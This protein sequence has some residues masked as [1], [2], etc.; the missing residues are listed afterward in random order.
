[1]ETTDT[2]VR[3]RPFLETNAAG[4][5][6]SNMTTV[7][8]CQHRIITVVQTGFDYTMYPMD[9]Q[10][11]VIRFFSL[12]LKYSQVHLTGTMYAQDPQ[13]DYVVNV[14]GERNIDKNPIWK[15]DSAD[16]TYESLI[17]AKSYSPRSFGY[18]TINIHRDSDGIIT[19]LALP[20]LLL[21]ILAAASFWA[22]PTDRIATT[23]TI[24][25]AVSGE[26]SYYINYILLLMQ[27]L[28]NNS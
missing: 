21:S 8:I 4:E 7:S 23:M 12:S 9:S 20:M 6:F 17:F 16:V 15:F 18:L 1:M 3:I 22:D 5:K 11:V 26:I 14:Q 25:L 19:R 2:F 27:R 28:I 10:V 13:V 24:L